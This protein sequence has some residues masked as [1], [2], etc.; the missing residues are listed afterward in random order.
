ML[1]VRAVPERSSAGRRQGNGFGGGTVVAFP[2]ECV[3]TRLNTLA[4][5]PTDTVSVTE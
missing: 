3:I 5:R 4:T 1:T 2:G